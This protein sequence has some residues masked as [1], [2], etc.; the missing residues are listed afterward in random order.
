MPSALHVGSARHVADESWPVLF[1]LAFSDSL[2]AEVRIPPGCD[3]AARVARLRLV[4]DMLI[5]AI[6]DL[7]GSCRPA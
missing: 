5:D 2:E 6:R 1:R 3:L 4:R 7:E